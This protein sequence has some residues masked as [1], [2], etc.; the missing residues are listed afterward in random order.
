MHDS[1]PEVVRCIKTPS[2]AARATLPTAHGGFQVVSF[3]DLADGGEHLA[4]LSGDVSGSESVLTRVHSE[5]LTGDAL[6]SLRCDCRAQLE[7]ALGR[8]AQEGPAMVLYLRQEGRGIGLCNK[9][10]SYELQDAGMDTVEANLA[11]GFRDDE[12]DY[13]VAQQMIEMLEVRSIRLMTNNPDKVRQLRDAGVLIEGREPHETPPTQH[14]AHY[15]DTKR[16]RS[17]H[18]LGATMPND[19]LGAR[20]PGALVRLAASAIVT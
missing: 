12:R 2:I 8:I 14:N 5:C 16:R 18:M 3:H 11:L 20:R 7:M 9:I 19:S 15:L 17:G 10:R 1:A 4:I 6:A 13:G